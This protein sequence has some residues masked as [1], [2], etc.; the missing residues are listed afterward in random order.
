ML[1][2]PLRV[3]RGVFLRDCL[4]VQT[5]SWLVPDSLK[6][7]EGTKIPI[8]TMRGER[9]ILSLTSSSPQPHVILAGAVRVP[10]GRIVG[11]EETEVPIDISF[12]ADDNQG[13]ETVR[14]LCCPFSRQACA[15]DLRLLT[16][17][18]LRRLRGTAVLVWSDGLGPLCLTY[19]NSLVR[20]ADCSA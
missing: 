18:M 11:D 9:E 4:W 10:A 8:I 7:I 1:S 15:Q 17:Q 19:Y 14:P 5:Q 20:Q 16:R 6:T 3:T 12:E 13:L 2:L